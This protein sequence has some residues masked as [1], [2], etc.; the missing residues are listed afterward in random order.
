MFDLLAF[1]QRFISKLIHLLSVAANISFSLFH[2]NVLLIFRLKRIS[3]TR[4]EQLQAMLYL[5]IFMRTIHVH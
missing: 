1:L 5:I 3:F 4:I 2:A